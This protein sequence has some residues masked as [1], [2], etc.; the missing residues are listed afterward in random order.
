M[1]VRLVE[2]DEG[3]VTICDRCGEEIP[4][5]EANDGEDEWGEWDGAMLCDDCYAESTADRQWP[6]SSVWCVAWRWAQRR[7]QNERSIT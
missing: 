6:S 3:N 1:D 5:D 2:E 7:L 4:L